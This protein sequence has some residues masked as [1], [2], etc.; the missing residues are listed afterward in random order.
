MRFFIILFICFIPLYSQPADSF[1]LWQQDTPNQLANRI[2]RYSK[3]IAELSDWKIEDKRM[4]LYTKQ[5][6]QDLYNDKFQKSNAAIARV[7]K[8]IKLAEKY[9]DSKF[10]DEILKRKVA[11]GMTKEMVID[12]WGKPED[13]NRTVGTWGV[14]EQWVYGHTYLYFED[15][16]LTSFQD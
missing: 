1:E 16:K 2:K 13:I 6:L 15:G 12:S 14:H 4:L 8:N 10:K 3:S 9:K 7:N 11:I 5:T